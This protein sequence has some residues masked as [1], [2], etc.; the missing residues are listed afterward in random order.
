VLGERRVEARLV[1]LEAC[2]EGYTYI[3]YRIEKL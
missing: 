2:F 1:L 3:T